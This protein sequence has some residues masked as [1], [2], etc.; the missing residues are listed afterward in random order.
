MEFSICRNNASKTEIDCADTSSR[1]AASDTHNIQSLVFVLASPAPHLCDVHGEAGC[2][3]SYIVVEKD[4]PESVRATGIFAD[5]KAASV[6]TGDM[7]PV[8]LS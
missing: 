4:N 8:V 5:R 3:G 2:I 7:I 6:F 1:H